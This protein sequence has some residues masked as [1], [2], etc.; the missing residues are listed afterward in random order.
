M[1]TVVNNSVAK[2]AEQLTQAIA[3]LTA[4]MDDL[5]AR[6]PT[7]CGQADA[8]DWETIRQTA[9]AAA[10]PADKRRNAAPTA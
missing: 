2:L 7:P 6:P 5:E 4:R 10:I 8:G 3:A 9:A 1:F